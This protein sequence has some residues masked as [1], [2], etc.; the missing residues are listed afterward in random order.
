MN[1]GAP[2]QTP[3]PLSSL[4]HPS[5]L[6]QCTGLEC[7]VSYIER[8]LVLCFTYGNTHVSMIFSQIIPP[9]PSPTESRSL[10]STPVSLLLSLC[11]C[12]AKTT[13]ILESNQPPIKINK[14][15]KNKIK[16]YL[17]LTPLTFAVKTVVPREESS[18]K[19]PL[20]NNP[21]LGEPQ[22]TLK[23]VPNLLKL[24]FYPGGTYNI[25]GKECI[26]TT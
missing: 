21:Y 8:G 5:G 9:S 6:S 1:T 25:I 17:K 20:L 11:Q 22:L 14:F 3:L 2:F 19:P 7:P 12:M 13:T 18:A 16:K 15:L 23:R 4:S 10:F 24:I 26:I